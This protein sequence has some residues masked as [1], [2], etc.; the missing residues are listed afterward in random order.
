MRDM[1]AEP[2]GPEQARLNTDGFESEEDRNNYLASLGIAAAAIKRNRA[3]RELPVDDIEKRVYTLEEMGL[4]GATVINRGMY[5]VRMSDLTLH[6]RVTN[7]VM[8][9]LDSVRVVN[10]YAGVLNYPPESIQKK[11]DGISVVLK[12]IGSSIEASEIANANPVIL[13][14]SMDKFHAMIDILQDAMSAE[15]VASLSAKQLSYFA[16]LPLDAVFAAV[17]KQKLVPGYADKGLTR[18]QIAAL[19]AKIPVAERRSQNLDVLADESICRAIG[20]RA[21][22]AYTSY[23]KITPE[24]LRAHSPRRRLPDALTPDYDKV[25]NTRLVP[26]IDAGWFESIADY[27]LDSE[28]IARFNDLIKKGS[29]RIDGTSRPSAEA[30]AARKDFFENTLMWGYK[31]HPLHE[32]YQAFYN[33]HPNLINPSVFV[34]L[35]RRHT[36]NGISVKDLIEYRGVHAMRLMHV[37]SVEYAPGTKLAKATDENDV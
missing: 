6:E 9:G 30:V 31:G 27:P 2:L 12:R 26:E 11:L 17:A 25:E 21:V 5:V 8:L 1:S 16:T 22:D 20:A 18:G 15:Y 35:A 36:R 7:L 14:L 29:R 32:K 4:N 13:G 37:N 19:Q 10:L 33:E 3:L 24:E 34:Y 23:A 28:D